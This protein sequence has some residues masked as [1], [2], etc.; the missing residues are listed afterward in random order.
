MVK[1]VDAV[2][3]RCIHEPGYGGGVLH[4]KIPFP[5][6]PNFEAMVAVF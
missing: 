3:D 6:A 5:E 1:V 4:V 2:S